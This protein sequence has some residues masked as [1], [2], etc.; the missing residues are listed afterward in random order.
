MMRIS[1]RDGTPEIDAYDRVNRQLGIR[2]TRL[3]SF[4]W[5]RRLLLPASSAELITLA[6]RRIWRNINSRNFRRILAETFA[7]PFWH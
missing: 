3:S 1:A 5:P 6:D 2:L 4:G 7:A